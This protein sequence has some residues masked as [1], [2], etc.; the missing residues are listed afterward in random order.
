M[1][2]TSFRHQLNS[3]KKF[4]GAQRQQKKLFDERREEFFFCS[5]VEENFKNL[6]AVL[7]FWYFSIKRKVHKKYS[8]RSFLE[9]APMQIGVKKSKAIN[10]F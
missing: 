6:F 3:V 2:I 8:F 9:P 4:S 5:G 7:I 1:I 10:I